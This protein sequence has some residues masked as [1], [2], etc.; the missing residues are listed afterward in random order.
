MDKINKKFRI[1]EINFSKLPWIITH[2][3][4]RCQN[5]ILKWF[6]IYVYL[7]VRYSLTEH[8]TT[9]FVVRTEWVLA[10]IGEL[11][12][13]FSENTITNHYVYNVSLSGWNNAAPK[14]RTI[15][16]LILVCLPKTFSEKSIP[17]IPLIVM[18]NFV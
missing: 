16:K 2:Y 10:L 3:A 4:C 13:A 11:F 7:P 14:W 1:M 8:K 18:E 12:Y 5:N 17:L 15:T 6:M 9:N